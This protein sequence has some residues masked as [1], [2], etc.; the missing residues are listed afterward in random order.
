MQ[1]M[2]KKYWFVPSDKLSG[3]FNKLS[4]TQDEI[5]LPNLKEALIRVMKW[6]NATEVTRIGNLVSKNSETLK[7]TK[8]EQQKK[9][10]MKNIY[11]FVKWSD[12]LQIANMD[13]SKLHD[14]IMID[15][16]QL[17]R[18]LPWLIKQYGLNYDKIN[19]I[20]EKTQKVKIKKN[21]YGQPKSIVKQ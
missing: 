5:S 18:D 1:V 2:V 6:R 15:T 13:V 21:P 10:I 9:H 17:Q 7:V 3:V 16:L 12:E 20:L 11:D 8:D 19:R 14:Q 4:E